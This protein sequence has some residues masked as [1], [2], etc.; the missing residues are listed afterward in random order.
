[1]IMALRRAAVLLCVSALL[2]SGCGNDVL[3]VNDAPDPDTVPPQDAVL[4][5]G[6]WPETAAWIAR[7]NAAGRPVVV[8]IFASWC[9]P[10]RREMPL[11][12][13]AAR[14]HNDIAFLGIDHLDQ[15]DN[16]EAFVEEYAVDI[17]TIY[18]VAGDVAAA[19]HARGMPTT[20]AFDTEGT[21]IA[22]HTGE[23]TASSLQQL[24]DDVTG[25]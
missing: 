8:N 16:A 21:L 11:L 18:D 4:A 2:I 9:V 3:S 23:L 13:D 17:P 1:M 10:C 5:D 20:V 25:S 22:H 19:L 24:L 12:L 14:A 15:R 7:E 6:G